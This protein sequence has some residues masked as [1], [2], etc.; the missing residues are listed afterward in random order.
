[1]FRIQITTE[2]A[3]RTS[4]LTPSLLILAVV[5]TVVLASSSDAAQIEA[6][7]GKHYRLTKR[8]GPWMIMV[9]S[10][11]EPPKLEKTEGMSPMQ[12]AE[13]LVY[14]L[15]RK[16]IP[17]YI[18]E[19]QE[20]EGNLTTVDRRTQEERKAKTR[21]WA[22]GICVL[23]G[24]Y[25]TANDAVAQTSLKFIKKYEPQFLRDLAAE[26]LA[27]PGQVLKRS[28]SG[29]VF[30][31]SA[32]RPGPLSGSFMTTNPLLT[33]EDLALRKR[34]PFILRLNTGS[35]YSLMQNPAKYT[36]VV[37]TFQGKSDIYSEGSE[38]KVRP[39]S[40]ALSDAA[41]RAWELC[42]ALR[43]A[44][45]YGYDRD[46]ES[47]IFHD[48]YSSIVTVGSFQSK[49]DPRI[50]AT[51]NLFGAKVAAVREDGSPSLGAE[52]FAIP[53]KAKANETVRTW[54]FDPFPQVIDIP[55]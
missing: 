35:D 38:K 22:G 8:H 46:Y 39:V 6:V 5:T 53:R 18:Y 55:R 44:K 17:A 52:A 28:Q 43:H 51:Q 13:E 16:G 10:F 37:A 27:G 20:V 54:I 1:V 26:A 7:R 42:T 32:N 48:R 50:I 47:W 41:E 4:T 21:N 30:R 49:D 15:R 9:A 29:G 34:D 3:V 23:A 31:T 12:A 11:N 33:E 36:V 40:S 14:E 19:Q 2:S 45:S 24:N 25:A